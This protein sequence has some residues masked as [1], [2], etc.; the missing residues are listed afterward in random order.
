MNTTKT[1]K[2]RLALVAALAI[3]LS[4]PA[5]AAPQGAHRGNDRSHHG[6]PQQHRSSGSGAGAAVLITALFGLTALA[7]AASDRQVV[8]QPAAAPYY[9][10]QYAPAPPPPPAQVMEPGPPGNWYLCPDNNIYYPY[11]QQCVSGWQAVR[12]VPLVPPHN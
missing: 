6:A 3:S 4:A 2:T 10:P 8:A 12:P 1:P 5:Y 9:P 7:V 11:V